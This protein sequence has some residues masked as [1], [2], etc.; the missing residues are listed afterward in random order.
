[1]NNGTLNNNG[2]TI[3]D[4]AVENGD[5]AVVGTRVC[6]AEELQAAIN[7]AAN[8]EFAN[9]ISFGANIAGNVTVL[10]NEG[11]NIVINGYGY[12]FDGVFTVN[13]NARAKGAETLTFKNINF[14]TEGDNITFIS[15]PSKVNGRYNYSH[16]VTVEDCTFKGNYTVGA[17]NFTGTYNFA[18]KNCVARNMHSLLQV[19]SVDNEVLVE[20]VEAVDC[21]NGI[22]FGNA[23]NPTLKNSVIKAK[24]Y[25]VRGDGDAL[26]GNLVIENT[27]IDANI[28]VIIRKVTS[29]GY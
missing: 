16:N 14:E 1:M 25:G 4:D 15:A 8:T 24:E 28:P 17:A 20:N 21:K 10:Q 7:N 13:G 5:D 22:S 2:G 23:A 27:S 11:I 12:K 18:M 26:R 3:A 19:Q 6:T 29:N 9:G